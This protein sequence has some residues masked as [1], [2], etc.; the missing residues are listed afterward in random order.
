VGKYERN[1]AGTGIKSTSLK[2]FD[3]DSHIHRIMR[4]RIYVV[5][6]GV[7]LT[8]VHV[9]QGFS[10]TIPTSQWQK[11]TVNPIGLEIFNEQLT[12]PMMTGGRPKAK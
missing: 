1:N 2:L 3:K 8:Y 12:W 6:Y 4:I 10:V 5:L 11:D 9:T 7:N